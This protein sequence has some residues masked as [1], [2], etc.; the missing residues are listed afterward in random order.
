MVS[1]K[2]IIDQLYED[3]NGRFSRSNNYNFDLKQL[4]IGSPDTVNIKQFPSISFYG[5]ADPIISSSIDGSNQRG[6]KILITGY[7]KASIWADIYELCEDIEKFLYSN[8]FGGDLD[9]GVRL[10]DE[11]PRFYV[12]SSMLNIGLACFDLEFNIQYTQNI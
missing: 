4:L 3:L 12:N 7:V 1:R 8:D 9:I 5:Y 6:F 10:D 2:I 11:G